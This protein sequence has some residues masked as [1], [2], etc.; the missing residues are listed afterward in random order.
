MKIPALFGV[1]FLL[2]LVVSIIYFVRSRTL[3]GSIDENLDDEEIQVRL[4]TEIYA[5]FMSW[6]DIREVCQDMAKDLQFQDI[7][8]EAQVESKALAMQKWAWKTWEQKGAEERGW[9]PVTDC[10]RLDDSFEKLTDQGILSLH[11]AGYT[12]SDGH[13]EVLEEV[14]DRPQDK[15]RG[16]CFYH[17]QDVERAMTDGVLYLAFGDLAEDGDE[18]LDLEVGK[19]IVNELSE[20]GFET[21]WD[22]TKQERVSVK[23]D[24][25]RRSP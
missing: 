24:Y 16:Y 2:L 1:L 11:N 25:K 23:L 10:D 15:F 14:D 5:G 6:D 17:G 18:S 9:A 7:I 21:V 3:T 20:A 8:P 13:Q 19:L 4:R 12:M 22:G